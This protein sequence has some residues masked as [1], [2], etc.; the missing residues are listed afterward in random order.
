MP[1]SFWRNKKVLITGHTGFKGSWLSMWL[2]QLGAQVVGLAL[3]PPTT[4]SLYELLQL[5]RSL[6]S[7][8]LDIRSAD[9]VGRLLREE[10]PE[11][12]FHLAA[13]ALVGASYRDPLTTFST[14]ILGTAVVCEA[15]RHAP[16]VQA[17]VV[18][19][20]DKC[21]E[22]K[23]WTYGYREIDRL[24]G[25]DPYSSSKACAELV[26]SCYQQ[27]F[28]SASDS[29]PF[30]ATAR[31]GNVIGG[32][33][34]AEGR[35]IPDVIRS[36]EA[37]RPLTIRRPQAQRP[38]QFVLEPLYGYL[39]L[40]EHLA[41]RGKEFTGPW[42]FG[43]D[44]AGIQSVE[45]VLRFFSKYWGKDLTINRQPEPAFHETHTLKLDSS[46]AKSL[47]RWCPR[48]TLEQSVELT[49]QWYRSYL[50]HED[51]EAVTQKQL[52]RYSALLESSSGSM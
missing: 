41:T 50:D 38:W 48:L 45:H 32:G 19:T 25:S 44:D 30:V 24:G 43:P 1:L 2:K 35:L 52:S 14:N 7:H 11:I 37:G 36:I 22:N 46:K 28:F 26:T 39:L 9:E 4:P 27:S 31:A 5:Q 10:S 3:D 34:W 20:T 21:Y 33:D 49:I 29:P 47:L 12:V 15:V 42:N 8:R 16:S 13:Q 6:K 40:A 17:M 51:L 18:V 23:E